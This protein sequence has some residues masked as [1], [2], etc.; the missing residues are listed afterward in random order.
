MRIQNPAIQFRTI[1][2]TGTQKFLYGQHSWQ[3]PLVFNSAAPSSKP[4]II[5]QYRYLI[6]ECF[7]VAI[8][9]SIPDI[10]HKDCKTKLYHSGKLKSITVRQWYFQLTKQ[11]QHSNNSLHNMFYILQFYSGKLPERKWGLLQLKVS[12]SHQKL[13]SDIEDLFSPNHEIF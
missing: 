7:Q 13:Q 11:S 3:G 4:E 10:R 2:T 6:L 12:K 1:S 8:D 9:R 5:I